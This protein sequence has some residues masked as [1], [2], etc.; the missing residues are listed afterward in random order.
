[1]SSLLLIKEELICLIILA[2]LLSY[3][4]KYCRHSTGYG[5]HQSHGKR[6]HNIF[7]IM[8]IS[9]IATAIFDILAMFCAVHKDDVPFAMTHFCLTCFFC[10]SVFFAYQFFVYV[11]GLVY[12][13]EVLRF[14]KIVF[15]LPVLL[16]V[17]AHHVYKLQ[18][19]QGEHTFYAHG[20]SI[21]FGY[22]IVLCLYFCAMVLV[23]VHY[24]TLEKT[25]IWCIIPISS[26]ILVAIIV[27][28]LYPEFHFITPDVTIVTFAVFFAI[29]NPAGRYQ[30]LAYYDAFTGLLNN[31]RY[32]DDKEKFNAL[33]AKNPAYIKNLAVV[34]C[35]VNSLKN[36]NDT[37]GHIA[38]DTLI[39][40]AARAVAK[41]LKS[42]HG[43]YRI[44]GD[45]FLA[46]YVDADEGVI[47]EEI[48]AIA[49]NCAKLGAEHNMHISIA[50]GYAMGKN[51]A[52]QNS[53]AD[54]ASTPASAPAN[55][56]TGASVASMQ[57]TAL[58]QEA[59]DNM[60]GHKRQMKDIAKQLEGIC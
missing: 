40:H 6:A 26:I 59:D 14:V 52:L 31:T 60:Y 27:Q 29:E 4:V 32:K 25:I 22:F 49:H 24:K 17:V 15:L 33:L 46:F 11:V 47:K 58:I 7:L 43:V 48:Q 5:A 13:K 16:Y 35:D 3:W 37:Q 30:K 19:A 23:L 53:F 21:K 12:S 9:A 50:T 38:G 18:I 45:E 51:L 28:M 56:R 2:F 57:I 42:A 39:S 41:G 36:V 55:S 8:C 20:T 54:N 10:I 1:M 34:I 44:G